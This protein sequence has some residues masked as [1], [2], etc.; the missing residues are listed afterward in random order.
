MLFAII[1]L[2]SNSFKMDLSRLANRGFKRVES[3]KSPVRFVSGINANGQLD[4]RTRE[5]ALSCLQTFRDQLDR[6]PPNATMAVATESFRRLGADSVF[7]QDAERVLGQKI[8]VLS[9][10]D[11]ARFCYHGVDSLLGPA[12]R[13]RLVVDIGGGSTQFIQGNATGIQAAASVSLGCVVLT[14]T[15]FADDRVDAARFAEAVRAAEAQYLAACTN[16]SANPTDSCVGASGAFRTVLEASADL[17][18]PSDALV[19]SALS[20]VTERL[21]ARGAFSTKDF[22]NV[23]PDRHAVF[24][25]CTALVA[26]VFNASGARSISVCKSGVRMGLLEHLYQRSQLATL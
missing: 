20:A 14:Q 11:E 8:E 7:L 2:G 10:E 1:D 17:G 4:P 9:G 21:C 6:N 26:A 18:G 3:F 12:Q 23:P 13:S 25:A 19:P 5:A 16:I 15:H 24:T 22:A